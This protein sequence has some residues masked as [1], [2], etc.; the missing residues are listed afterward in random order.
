MVVWG[1]ARAANFVGMNLRAALSARRKTTFAYCS[2]LSFAACS[3][4]TVLDVP[5]S[6]HLY[7]VHNATA[8]NIWIGALDT[9][10][11]SGDNGDS[12]D[13]RPTT[14]SGGQLFGLYSALHAFNANT[15]LITGT[16]NTGTAESIYR[17]TD[18]GNGDWDLVHYQNVDLLD[19]LEDLEFG[20]APLGLAVGTNGRI[21]RTTDSGQN[22]APVATPITSTLSSVA[23]AGGNVYLAGGTYDFLRSTD[24]GLTWSSVFSPSS[25]TVVLAQGSTCYAVSNGTVWKSTN[26]GANWT[27]MGPAVGDVMEMLDANTLV[28]ANYEGLFRSTTGGQFW[29]QFQLPQYEPLDQIDFRDALN[30]IA[31]GE[32]GYAIRTANG[33]GPT[34]PVVALQAPQGPYCT[35]Q[36]VIMVNSGDP[37]WTY[38]WLVDGLLAASTPQ[39]TTTFSEAGIHEVSLIAFNGDGYDTASVS[40]TVPAGAV[41]PTFTAYADP[42]TVCATAST[43]IHIN[44]TQPGIVYRLLKNGVQVGTP[45]S[46]NGTV[47]VSTGAIPEPYSLVVMATI[48]NACGSDTLRVDV[49]VAVTHVSPGASWAL[50][51]DSA[52]APVTPVVRITDSGLGYEYTVNGFVGFAGNGG[53]LDI[54]QDP[55]TSIA[56]VDFSVRTQFVDQGCYMDGVSMGPVQQMHVWSPGA[57]FQPDNDVALVGQTMGMYNVSGGGTSYFWDLGAGAVPATSTEEEPDAVFWTTPGVKTI[58]LTHIAGNNVCSDQQIRTVTVVDSFPDQQFPSCSEGFAGASAYIADMY[59]DRYNNRYLTGQYYP[60]GTANKSFFAM[61]LDST[62]QVVW[63]YKGP[64][65]FDGTSIGYG[66]TA[67]LQ[68]NAYVTGLFGHENRQIQGTAVVYPQFIVKF[69]REGHRVWNISSPSNKFRG[70]A[71]TPDNRIHV[72][73]YGGGIGLKL[74]RSGGGYWNQFGAIDDPLHGEAFL[75][76]MDTAGN[77]LAMDQFGMRHPQGNPGGYSFITCNSDQFD[78]YAGYRTDPLLRAQPDGSLLITGLIGAIRNGQEAVFNTT[79]LVNHAGLDTTANVRQVYVAS[80]LPGTGF[81]QAA[82]VMGGKMEE[83]QGLSVAPDGDL[84]LC[85]RFRNAFIRDDSLSSHTASNG[86]SQDYYNYLVRASAQGQV[87]WQAI[88]HHATFHDVAAGP[89]GSCY[90]L[91]SFTS[92]GVIPQGNGGLTGMGSGNDAR[93]RAVLHYAADGTLLNAEQSGGGGADIAFNLRPDACGN[94]HIAALSSDY[95]DFQQEHTIVYCQDC[96]DNLSLRVLTVG[97]CAADCYAAYNPAS[98]DVAL[99]ALSLSD[100]AIVSPEVRVRFR[101]AGQVP[102][103]NVTLAYRVNEGAVQTVDWSGSIAYA[104]AVVDLPLA[105]L[106]F[107]A[108]NLARVRVWIQSVN[109]TPDDDPGNDTLAL[110]HTRCF[111]PIH[112][113]Y[114]CGTIGSDFPTMQDATRALAQCGITGPTTIGIVPGDYLG[115]LDILPIPG[116]SD[117]DTVVFTSLNDDSASVHLSFDAVSVFDA[118]PTVYFR[119]GVSHVTVKDLSLSQPLEL[120]SNPVVGLGGKSE[121]DRVSG[122]Q[123]NGILSSESQVLLTKVGVYG[124]W[125]LEVDGCTFQYGKRGIYLSGGNNS[126]LPLQRDSLLTIQGNVFMNQYDRGVEVWIQRGLRMHGNRFIAITSEPGYKAVNIYAGGTLPYTFTNNIVQRHAIFMTGLNDAAWVRIGI[127]ADAVGRSLIANNMI[128]NPLQDGQLQTSSLTVSGGHVDILHNTIGGRMRLT[129]GVGTVLRDNIFFSTSQ[130]PVLYLYGDHTGLDADGNLF[131]PGIGASYPAPI[132]LD[133]TEYNLGTWTG[134]T[135]EDQN[136]FM[137][138]PQFVSATDLHLSPGANEFNSPFAWV[139]EDIDG[140]PR[141]TYAPRPGADEGDNSVLV[142]RPVG[143]SGVRLWPTVGD[144]HIQLAISSGTKGAL[145]V[146]VLDALGQVV[147]T[148][149]LGRDPGTI[150]LRFDLPSAAYRLAVDMDGRR[151]ANLPM[152]IV[153]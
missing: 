62:G 118:F 122:C 55:E 109:G 135:A 84:L 25:A 77:V 96:T 43:T 13:A 141:S 19:L 11:W 27:S 36:P 130:Y 105:T 131:C 9:I 5:A 74:M 31:V 145:N 48:S 81:Q 68:G 60:G 139:F 71:C 136:S 69:D 17:T 56:T 150:A 73:G 38:Q 133:G 78:T 113:T 124:S 57:V 30:G 67:D 50:V 140:D 76:S 104:E 143:N 91:A 18:G 35:G 12:F 7:S 83:V 95:A 127:P 54:P 4:W 147:S 42:D 53:V 126:V 24:G 80:Y 112:G 99:E 22:W 66:I 92:T 98:R 47:T 21:L 100:T 34:V 37:T 39:F 51:T 111:A 138:Q 63:Q 58:T 41:V 10:Y 40:L 85:G 107:T 120:P 152:I 44:G 90:V 32:N 148:K 149:A 97:D 121:Y 46:G 75:I 1:Y 151:V 89:D 93:D 88:T 87:L 15:A 137:L 144:G 65:S 117:Q 72:V 123:L 52:C 23:W 61:K 8:G 6:D 114:T 146:L 82:L 86:Y 20:Q 116:T 26:A 29:E 59:L 132:D 134:L 115:Q 33:G 142:P 119:H 129:P 70:I 94:L 3:Q 153:R 125:G 79:A 106:D 108:Y 28:A 103:N 64:P 128:H 102:A 14:W 49:P 45:F 110:A 2:L 101:N 16:M